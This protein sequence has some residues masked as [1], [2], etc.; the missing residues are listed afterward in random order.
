MITFFVCLTIL[1]VGYFTYG[2]VV[3]K[4]LAPNDEHL[5][6]AKRLADGI[7]YV[8]LPW[9][10]VLLTQFLNIA[11]LGPIFG[12]ILGAL[13]GP[14]AFIWI[15]LGCLFVGSVA[16]MLVG[17]VSM[18]HDGLSITELVGLYLGRH[19]QK[20]MIVFTFILLVLVGVTF[21]MAP[22]A[23]LN[24]RMPL[25]SSPGGV[26][27]MWV[28]IIIAYYVFATIVPVEALIAKLFP[29]LSVAMLAACIILL[30][31]L[32]M[33]LGSDGFTMMEFSFEN[34]QPQGQ[35][36][37][38]FI[39]TTI[40]CGAVS[41]FHATKSPMMARCI[42][43][44][45]EAKRV[46]FGSMIIEGV[47]ALIW[48]AITMAVLGDRLFVL[49]ENAAG[50]L[51]S[52]VGYLGGQ[53]GTVDYMANVLLPTG[54][55]TVLIFTAVIIFPITSAD[56]GFRSVRLMFAD[57]FKW[58]QS[59]VINRVLVSI[60][61]FVIAW[62][63]TWIDFGIIWRY[64]AW[65]NLS[66]AAIALWMG[67]RYLASLKKNYWIAVIPASILSYG[68]LSYILQAPEGFQLGVRF[69][70]GALISNVIGIVF[71]LVLFA[72][73]ITSAKSAPEK[74]AH[75]TEKITVD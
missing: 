12:A 18:K 72:L 59:K 58:D 69:A 35:A 27:W 43:K 51:V 2:K 75:V 52:M 36:F 21:T 60:P 31:A 9:W 49:R 29:P 54:L 5:T 46:F 67:A 65:S 1:I 24:G 57:A 8:E 15:T 56:T 73:F 4:I 44:E 70:N 68:S 39:F 25:P 17:F 64:F 40:A 38:P 26:P 47:V 74:L 61:I 30:I 3:D 55:A 63:L 7:D 23:W 11:G 6:P 53:G 14:I 37:F 71:A 22:A 13:F 41:G 66:I 45:S 33:N 50:N 34:L 62:I 42:G 10:K 19:T 16:D 48:A 28:L 20:F 32:F